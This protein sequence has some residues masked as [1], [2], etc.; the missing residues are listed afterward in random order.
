M[1]IFLGILLVVVVILQ[2]VQITKEAC[3]SAALDRLTASVAAVNTKADSAIALIQGLAQLIRDNSENPAALN[4]LADD[5]D[6]QSSELQQA[7]DAN[8]PP[9]EPTP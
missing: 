3:M 1:L 7:I 5:L 6:A 8:T 9:V 2:L 4:K